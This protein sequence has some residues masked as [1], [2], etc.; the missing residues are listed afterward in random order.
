MERRYM[1]NFNCRAISKTQTMKT[2]A[3][4]N[5]KTVKC[6][7]LLKSTENKRQQT[8]PDVKSSGAMMRSRTMAVGRSQTMK[9]WSHK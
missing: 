3:R 6:L 9:L 5:I 8:G 1:V 4:Q 7:N 2:T